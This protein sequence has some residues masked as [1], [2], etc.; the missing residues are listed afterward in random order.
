[1]T[2]EERTK[3]ELTRIQLLLSSARKLLSEAEDASMA[4]INATS[5]EDACAYR[6]AALSCA[7]AALRVL[8][9]G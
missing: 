5:I 4:A 2:R 8:E 9:V 6:T 7:T 3:I 1:M